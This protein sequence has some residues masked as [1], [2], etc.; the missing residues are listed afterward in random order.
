MQE[1]ANALLLVAQRRRERARA[2]LSLLG[3]V[4]RRSLECPTE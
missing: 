3:F 4:Q 2:K 1:Q